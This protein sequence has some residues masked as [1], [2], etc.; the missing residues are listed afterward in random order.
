VRKHR[1]IT[2]ATWARPDIKTRSN[3]AACHPAAE[4]GFYEDE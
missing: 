2:E 4:R 3:C 1:H